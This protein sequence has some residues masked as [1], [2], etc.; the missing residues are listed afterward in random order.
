MTWAIYNQSTPRIQCLSD[1]SWYYLASYVRFPKWSRTWKVS[2]WKAGNPNPP[3]RSWNGSLSGKAT[4][5]IP[6]GCFCFYHCIQ[7]SCA[8][9]PASYEGDTA[10]KACGSWNWLLITN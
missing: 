5:V 8:T 4:G 6:P 9:S 2:H 10:G 3:T 7:T 1:P